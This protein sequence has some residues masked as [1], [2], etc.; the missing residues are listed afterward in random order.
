MELYLV[1]DLSRPSQFL[2]SQEGDLKDSSSL[3]D[4]GIFDNPLLGSSIA[5]DAIP[6]HTSG[7]L[8]FQ[9]L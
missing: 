2:E 7:G 9:E 6:W 4:S 1:G 5:K 8:L 3:N